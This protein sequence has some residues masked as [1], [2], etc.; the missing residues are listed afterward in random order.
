MPACQVAKDDLS[1]QLA[2]EFDLQWDGT[3]HFTPLKAPPVPSTY[4]IGL[5]V[6]P[7]G[8]GKTLLLRHFGRPDPITW[9]PDRT[10]ASHFEDPHHA[11]QQL[12]AAGLNSVPT[13]LKPFHVLSTG[14]QFRA[15]L[16][17]RLRSG[18]VLDEFTSVV[19][20]NVALTTS[21]ALRKFVDRQHL[22][23]ITIATC[24]FDVIRW[25][26]PDWIFNTTNSVL[27]ARGRL[28]R[29]AI[30]IQVH[31]CSWRTWP[32]FRS[33]HYLTGSIHK[34]A[35]CFLGFWNDRPV[36]FTAVLAFPHP[37]L[38]KAF[39]EHRTVVLPDYQGA[40]IGPHF[41]DAIAQLYLDHGCKYYSR[42]SHP[43]MGEYRQASPL[44]KP[45]PTNLKR[46]K[47]T[48]SQTQIQNHWTTDTLRT[49]YSHQ[50]VGPP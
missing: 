11:Q 20:R 25:L 30:H 45:T 42:T 19:D 15:D 49:C 7:S 39:R 8:T 44:W 35:Q 2:Q 29:P 50:F 4:G 36:V 38:K 16:A 17:R 13:W 10:I 32:H 6:G 5:I 43:R 27:D 28:P 37:L 12:T 40:G 21:T 23:N 22:T 47:P 24:H 18:A 31:R 33:H 41:S 48:A 1:V 9:N 14:E 34:Q 26:E 3:S 46:Q